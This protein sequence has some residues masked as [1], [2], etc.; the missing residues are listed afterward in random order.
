[1]ADC[2]PDSLY[3]KWCD[4]LGQMAVIV[5]QE[6][7]CCISH[8]LLCLHVY[9][10][11]KRNVYP[12]SWVSFSSPLT[13]HVACAH[14]YLCTHR[15]AHTYRPRETPSHTFMISELV[16]K[17]KLTSHW[18]KLYFSCSDLFCSC[19][20]THPNWFTYSHAICIVLLDREKEEKR[21]EK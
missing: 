7:F 2:L 13:T 17:W 21:K 3:W 9:W 12:M 11:R 10:T 14:T 16:S 18:A 4:W 19:Q 1:M 15:C 20:E 5:E 6:V 8:C